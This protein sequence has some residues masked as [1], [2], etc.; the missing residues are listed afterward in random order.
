MTEGTGDGRRRIRILA[1][2]VDYRKILFFAPWAFIAVGALAY[3]TL[4]LGHQVLIA[5]FGASTAIVFGTPGGRL[6]R[7][8][9]VFFGHVASSA[10]GLVC[11][12]L[13]GCTWYSIAIAVVLAVVF[14]VFTDTFHPPGGATAIL[15][16]MSSP[17]WWFVIMPVAVGAL[18]LIAVAEVSFRLYGR[19]A[20]SKAGAI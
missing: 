18:I 9:N 15:T 17:Q 13:M 7:P 19:H 11:Y 5:S 2:D 16:V 1:D 3:I 4:D 14:M 12:T 20:G 6:A 8:R 10:I